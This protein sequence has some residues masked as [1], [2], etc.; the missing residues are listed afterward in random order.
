[1]TAY[2]CNGSRARVCSQCAC[3]APLCTT[4]EGARAPCA[5]TR[6][7]F[8]RPFLYPSETTQIVYFEYYRIA[9]Y[10]TGACSLEGAKYIHNHKTT[11]NQQTFLN[12]RG[13]DKLAVVC[14]LS[15][16]GHT[17]QPTPGR[18]PC[19]QHFAVW[20]P[21]STTARG[22]SLLS[23]PPHPTPNL[24]APSGR[25]CVKPHAPATANPRPC[26]FRCDAGR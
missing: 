11:F 12:S 8:S 5:R 9:T 22:H 4:G 21:K 23:S 15:S 26:R 7:A 16:R 17:P 14:V 24:R 25:L 20:S 6:T 10:S 18:V 1:M 19:A 3:A 13:T 2:V